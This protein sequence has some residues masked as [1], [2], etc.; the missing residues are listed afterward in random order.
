MLCP[1]SLAYS[2]DTG[3][4]VREEV[5][6]STMDIDGFSARLGVK[7]IAMNEEYTSN[8]EE[9]RALLPVRVTKPGVKPTMKSKWVNSKEELAD[10]DWNQEPGTRNTY[11]K[12]KEDDNGPCG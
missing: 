12:T 8:I 10:D 4:I 1:S 2:V 7:Y 6:R 5:T 11:R 3:R 9:V